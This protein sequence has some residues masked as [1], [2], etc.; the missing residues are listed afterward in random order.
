VHGIA[1]HRDGEWVERG[2]V[3]L[4]QAAEML[5]L[6]SMT[7]LRKVRAGIIP[8]EQYCK[9]APWV[10]KRRDIEDPHLIETVRASA[11]GPLSSSA[12]QESL[13]FQ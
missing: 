13:Y 8:G 12:E 3:T 11:K 7:V 5:N 2:E 6:S 4:A 1:V 10:I 9:G